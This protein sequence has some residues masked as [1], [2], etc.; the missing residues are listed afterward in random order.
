LLRRPGIGPAEERAVERSVGL[1][2]DAGFDCHLGSRT[3]RRSAGSCPCL[4]P[5][6]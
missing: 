4:R 3:C 5:W 1:S 2:R 6:G